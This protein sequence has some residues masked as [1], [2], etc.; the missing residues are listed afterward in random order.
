MTNAEVDF[1]N[2]KGSGENMIRGVPYPFYEKCDW[3]ICFLLNLDLNLFF[4]REWCFKI[5]RS[6]H[7]PR[8]KFILNE[9]LN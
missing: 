5:I 2:W 6:F 1:E 7:V 9:E 4:L 8:I 3:A